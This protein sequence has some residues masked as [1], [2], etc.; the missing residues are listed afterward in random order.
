GTGDRASGRRWSAPI[1]TGRRRS[2]AYQD[3]SLGWRGRAFYGVDRQWRRGGAMSGPTGETG[4]DLTLLIP[5]AGRRD[6][7]EKLFGSL[8]L[9][10]NE[11][12]EVL[13]GYHGCA[14]SMAEHLDKLPLPRERVSHYF[15][16]AGGGI[17][18][19]WNAGVQRARGRF[20]FI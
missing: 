14:E 4:I 2:R 11:S 12:L 15:L 7:L 19:N 18:A 20:V 10:G 16:P 8:N 3:V 6:Y 17:P 9:R 5:T 1:Q 13:V